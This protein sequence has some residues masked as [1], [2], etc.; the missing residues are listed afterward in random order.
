MSKSEAVGKEIGHHFPVQTP[1]RGLFMLCCNWPRL[2]VSH[3]GVDASETNCEQPDGE[4]HLPFWRSWGLQCRLLALVVAKRSRIIPARFLDALRRI[5][6]AAD[7]IRW[8]GVIRNRRG[9]LE[10]EF[11]AGGGHNSGPARS[12]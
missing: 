8:P 4:I 1:N 9:E 5:F 6:L 10:T 12:G 2:Q 11:W 3:G 7:Q